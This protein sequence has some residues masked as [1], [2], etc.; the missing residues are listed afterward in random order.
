MLPDVQVAYATSGPAIVAINLILI[1]S[2]VPEPVRRHLNAILVA[3]SCGVYQARRP[4]FHNNA[5]GV[6]F[7]GTGI[8]T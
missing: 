1:M 2:R 7:Y 8:S 5:I 4:W 3:G 6:H